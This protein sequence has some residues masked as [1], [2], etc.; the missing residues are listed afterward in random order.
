MFSDSTM[1]YSVYTGD[2][3]SSNM[4]RKRITMASY[5]SLLSLTMTDNWTPEK[6]ILTKG[7]YCWNG[8]NNT[9]SA[10]FIDNIFDTEYQNLA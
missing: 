2:F 9:S 8:M 6:L 7:G 3:V 1:Y 10:F 5:D 4:Y